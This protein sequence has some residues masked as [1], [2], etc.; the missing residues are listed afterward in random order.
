MHV[1]A[2][3]TQRIA[4]SSV[5]ARQQSSNCGTLQVTAEDGGDGTNG[6]GGGNGGTEPSDQTF[7]VVLALLAILAFTIVY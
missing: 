3:N 5:T 7:A 6:D 2:M 1:A 4:G